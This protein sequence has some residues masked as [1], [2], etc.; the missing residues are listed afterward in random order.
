MDK[1]VASEGGSLALLEVREGRVRVKYNKGYNEECPECVPDHGMV[2]DML[3]T[4]FSVHAPFVTE[5]EV[6]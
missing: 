1:V 2:R 6:V 5:V 4:A 3:K